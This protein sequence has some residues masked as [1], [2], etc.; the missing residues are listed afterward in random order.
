MYIN[1]SGPTYSMHACVLDEGSYNAG[2]WSNQVG[3]EDNNRCIFV[4]AKHFCV[5]IFSSHAC[6]LALEVAYSVLLLCMIVCMYAFAC[7]CMV[8]FKFLSRLE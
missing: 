2:M 6:E 8:R 4:L 5:F 1:Y 3:K 7:T